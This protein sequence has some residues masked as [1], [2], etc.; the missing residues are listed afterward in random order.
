MKFWRRKNKFLLLLLSHLKLQTLPAQCL[1]KMEKI[2]FVGE[3]RE[4]KMSSSWQQSVVLENTELIENLHV[5][6]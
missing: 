2:K 1:V 5:Y 6:L 4:Q 3:R